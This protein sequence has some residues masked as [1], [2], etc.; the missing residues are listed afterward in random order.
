MG[1]NAAVVGADEV[2]AS[3]VLGLD[4]LDAMLGA[5]AG[6]GRSVIGPTVRDGSIVLEPIEGV[7]DLPAGWTDEQDA[8]RYRLHRRGDGAVFGWAVG[9]HSWRQFLFPP[10]SR[11]WR[12]ERTASQSEQAASETPVDFRVVEGAEPAERY[13]FVGVRSCDL[14]AIAVHDRVFLGGEYPDPIYAD[15]RHDVFV[16]AVHCGDPAGTC[17]CTSMG[18]GPR[19]PGGYDIALTELI[20]ADRHELLAE[21]ASARGAELL[22]ALTAGLSGPS[23]E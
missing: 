6:E 14:H 18:T 12:A 8:G 17:F 5:L 11:L 22:A 15:R 19:A 13:A 20:D 4:G 10:R 7:G 1:E 21:A 23:Y 9:A 2:L 16:V 3:V